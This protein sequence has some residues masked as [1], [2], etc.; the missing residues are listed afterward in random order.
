[1]NVPI[2]LFKSYSLI[3]AIIVLK[4]V[5]GLDVYGLDVARFDRYILK[6]KLIMSFNIH[7]RV[8]VY[9]CKT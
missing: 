2:E 4:I 8:N 7:K 1:M 3:I 5:Y 6:R 9:T